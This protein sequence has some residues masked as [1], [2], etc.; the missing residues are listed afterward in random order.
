LV[1]KADFFFGNNFVK[2]PIT[3][4]LHTADTKYSSNLIILTN[5]L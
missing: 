3:L 5:P 1:S 4:V 2:T